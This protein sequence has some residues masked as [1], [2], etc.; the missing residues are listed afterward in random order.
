MNIHALVIDTLLGLVVVACWL[1]VI[2]MLRMHEPTQAL[3]Y[4]TLPATVGVFALVLGVFLETGPAFA[5]FKTLLIA[6]I[7][8]AINAVVTHATARA[9]RTRELGHW[10]PQD[11]DPIEFVPST[12]HTQESD[13]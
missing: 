5:A 4:L 1:G 6:V 3:H 12:H 9:F 10:Q 8:F 11:G 7:L 2:G 13:S